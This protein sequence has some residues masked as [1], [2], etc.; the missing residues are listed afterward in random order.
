MKEIFA[1]GFLALVCIGGWKLGEHMSTDAL[2]MWLGVLFGLMAGIPAALM[3]AQ[4]GGRVRHDH[5]VHEATQPR[6]QQTKL[7]LE[8]RAKPISGVYYVNIDDEELLISGKELREQLVAMADKKIQLR[9]QPRY[10][11]VDDAAKTSGSTRG[12]LE[13]K[14]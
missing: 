9:R 2:T 3:V 14:R 12:R 5:Y 6:Q 10:T 4:R 7:E 1:I 13:V 11:V 8:N